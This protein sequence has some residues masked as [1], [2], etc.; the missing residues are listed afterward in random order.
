MS[1]GIGA[2]RHSQAF[3]HFSQTRRIPRMLLGGQRSWAAPWLIWCHFRMNSLQDHT[4]WSL[5]GSEEYAAWHFERLLLLKTSPPLRNWSSFFSIFAALN[6]AVLDTVMGHVNVH[7]D[8][9]LISCYASLYRASR[10]LVYTRDGSR[11]ASRMRRHMSKTFHKVTRQ[12][13]PMRCSTWTPNSVLAS[14]LTCSR[15]WHNLRALLVFRNVRARG[16]D[17]FLRMYSRWAP[18]TFEMP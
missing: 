8:C 9:H 7:I 3:A 1:R 10:G 14:P 18:I 11:G 17:E 4:R 16:G 15:P 5:G 12:T 6:L 2:N 13:L